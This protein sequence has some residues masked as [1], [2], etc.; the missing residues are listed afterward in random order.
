VVRRWGGEETADPQTSRAAYPAFFTQCTCSTRTKVQMLTAGRWQ[1]W[2]LDLSGNSLDTSCGFCIGTLAG[3]DNFIYTLAVLPNGDIVSGGEDRTVRVWHDGLFSLPAHP[4]Q[5]STLK[6][7]RSRR[8]TTRTTTRFHLPIPHTSYL[9]PEH[10]Q[11]QRMRIR[12]L[13]LYPDSSPHLTAL[14]T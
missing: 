14:P 3:H 4:T 12:A 11:K 6:S 9:R 1:M 7:W 5:L 2:S 13:S 10:L 8:T